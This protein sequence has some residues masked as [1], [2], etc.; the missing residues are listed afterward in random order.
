MLDRGWPT[1]LRG[2][3]DAAQDFT[4]LIP[5]RPEESRGV[6][7]DIFACERTDGWFPRQYSVEGPE[8]RHDLR[9]YVDAGCWIW[10]YLYDYVRFTGDTSILEEKVRWLDSRGEATVL[11]HAEALLGYYMN[12]DNL[13]EHGLVKIRAGDW[14]DS[15]NAAGIEGRGESV[16]VSCQVVLAMQQAAE[17]LGREGRDWSQYTAFGARMR[18]NIRGHAL[19]SEGYL[20]GVFN[21]AGK[22]VFSP[23][24][25]DGAHRI[26]SPVNSFGIIAGVFEEDE[27]PR[28]FER[29]ESLK[30]ANGY[31]LF[32]P[33]IGLPPISNLG[34][35]GQGDML[36]GV[37]ENGNPYNHGSHGFLGRA[38]AS[39]GRGDL[40]RDI[41]K[42]MLPYNQEAHP[43]DVAR[44][45]PYGVVNHWMSIDGQFGRGGATFLSGSITTAL[46]NVYGGMMGFQPTR[47]GLRIDPALPSGW[48]KVSFMHNYRGGRFN[49]T[50]ENPNGVESGV[51]Y[52][53]IGG[54]RI[55]A[56]TIPANII[57]AG[58]NVVRVVLGCPCCCGG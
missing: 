51:A 6:L 24:D 34:R 35:I 47:D 57:A 58:T 52:I 26:N 39:A 31:S 8:G 32:L 33:G 23:K 54:K 41:F 13:G 50:I 55:D 15:V 37:G 56:D 29:L 7:L 3:R 22:W 48:K 28:V 10:E 16:M 21:D 11:E 5:L 36:P 9:N 1:G 42:Y 14:N 53:E 40:L 17:L 2:S 12:D 25:P 43:V 45:A 4:G 44:T 19:N 38:A 27:L 20:N 30:R 49:V 18:E 46:R